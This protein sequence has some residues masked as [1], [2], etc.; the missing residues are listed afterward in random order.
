[1]LSIIFWRP[2]K[3]QAAEA[4]RKVKTEH[5]EHMKEKGLTDEGVV[6]PVTDADYKSNAIFMN[7]FRNHFPG[8]ELV[9]EETE[10]PVDSSIYVG[11]SPLTKALDWNPE[12][13]LSRTLVEIDPLDATK[14]FSEDLLSYVT[15]MVCIIYDD[16][17]IAGIIYQVFE[18]DPPV[19]GIV[20]S[21]DGGRGQ[22][23]GRPNWGPA[24]GEAASKI[25]IS[26]SHTGA[27]G[28]VV[29]KYLD[30]STALLAGG[31]GYKALLVLDGKATGYV[32]VTKIKAWDVCA[33]DAVLRAAGG[34]FT[35]VNGKV[36]SYGK[37]DP[38]FTDGIVAAQTKD[39]HVKLVQALGGRL[40]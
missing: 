6:E 33:A 19:V 7:G 21:M 20:G 2:G 13:D 25:A 14:E 35:D 39:D 11:T 27:G 26:R 36:L 30:G 31:A 1:M 16:R 23:Q 29:E 18:E 9:S 10:P 5:K 3:Y 12:L 24:H 40:T 15:T 37:G 34:G 8:I 38:V 17:P 4:I 22:I 28:S 32:H